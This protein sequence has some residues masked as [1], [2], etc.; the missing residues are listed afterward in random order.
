MLKSLNKDLDAYMAG[1]NNKQSVMAQI[2]SA[3]GGTTK[4]SST[5]GSASKR[6]RSFVASNI[7]EQENGQTTTALML[8]NDPT[9]KKK[10]NELLKNRVK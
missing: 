4:A 9:A 1:I 2:D 5:N 3:F 10:R 7:K 6:N 8:H